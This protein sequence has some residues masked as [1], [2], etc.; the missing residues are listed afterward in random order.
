MAAVLQFTL[1][2][3]PSL[4]YGDEIFLSGDNTFVDGCR[5]PFDWNWEKSEKAKAARGFYKKLIWVRRSEKALCQGSFKILFADDDTILYSRFTR[6]EVIFTAAS[7]SDEEKEIFLPLEQ[8]DI[9]SD[10]NSEVLLGEEIIVKEKD[11]KSYIKI[12]PHSAGIIKF[13]S[14]SKK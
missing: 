9:K 6:D 4:Y 10:C 1:P 3:T 14:S 2:G 5:D 12:P 8:F 11:K 13:F 7:K